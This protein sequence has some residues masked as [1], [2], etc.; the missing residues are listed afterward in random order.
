[1]LTWLK[2]IIICVRIKQLPRSEIR[3]S[4]TAGYSQVPGSQMNQTRN[5]SSSFRAQL[6]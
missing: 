2:K 3:L 4:C 1:M 5:M 6:Y